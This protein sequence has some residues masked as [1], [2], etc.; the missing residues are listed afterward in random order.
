MPSEAAKPLLR[1]L[2]RCLSCVQDAS[3]SAEQ[4][5][6]EPARRQGASVEEARPPAAT[7]PRSSAAVGSASQ[8]A[9]HLGTSSRV[10]SKQD[11]RRAAGKA[12][13]DALLEGSLRFKEV[14]LL[15]TAA[16]LTLQGSWA[17]GI[18][19]RVLQGSFGRCI[20]ERSGAYEVRLVPE[21]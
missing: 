9:E 1:H 6:S 15:S 19:L 5:S 20:P 10:T 18:D 7:Q 12:A 14:L 4:P 21:L 2:V 8:I 16:P 3:S 11:L 17:G 13:L